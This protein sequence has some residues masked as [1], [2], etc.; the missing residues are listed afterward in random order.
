MHSRHV[1]IIMSRFSKDLYLQLLFVVLLSKKTL[2]RPQRVS[3]WGGEQCSRSTIVLHVPSQMFCRLQILFAVFWRRHIC[4]P[5]RCECGRHRFEYF[6]HPVFCCVIMSFSSSILPVVM[7]WIT[8]GE[9]LFF[10]F[11][12]TLFDVQCES[13][14]LPANVLVMICAGS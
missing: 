11:S 13:A 7:H 10:E 5:M 3:R 9:L 1:F 4:L 12:T 6:N 2:T 8:S 14:R